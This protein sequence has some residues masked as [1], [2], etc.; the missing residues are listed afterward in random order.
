MGLQKARAP[1]STCSRWAG[2]ISWC[3]WLDLPTEQIK[4]WSKGLC[5]LKAQSWMS[6]IMVSNPTRHKFYM[7]ALNTLWPQWQLFSLSKGSILAACETF[8]WPHLCDTPSVLWERH[9]PSGENSN[10]Q[11]GLELKKI[12]SME[13]VGT[14]LG[15]LLRGKACWGNKWEAFAQ[16]CPPL[17]LADGTSSNGINPEWGECGLDV[18]KVV[19]TVKTKKRLEGTV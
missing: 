12:S 8:L 14:N 18:R 10:Q 2:D 17:S 19:P 6:Q 3:L 9:R 5:N 4:S 7:R 15:F 11:E 1:V 13:K 16:S